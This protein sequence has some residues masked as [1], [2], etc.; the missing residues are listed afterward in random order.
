MRSSVILLGSIL[1]KLERYNLHIGSCEIGLRPIE[2]L[3]GLKQLSTII[4]ENDIYTAKQRLVGTDIHLDYPSVGATENSNWRRFLPRQGVIS[5]ARRNSGLAGFWISSAVIYMVQF[6]TIY[7]E[8]FS[9]INRVE[10]RIIPDRIVAGT[11]M[12]A[13]AII[14]VCTD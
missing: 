2:H 6:H 10:Y 5:T 12:L 4:N 13:A 3:K 7:I 11:Y 9:R 8:G 1:G 14:R